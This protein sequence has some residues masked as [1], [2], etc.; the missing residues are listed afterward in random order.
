MNQTINQK[1]PLF[2][3]RKESLDKSILPIEEFKYNPMAG[4]WE[5]SV[6]EAIINIAFQNNVAVF[7]NTN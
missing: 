3:F 2:L 5:N 6:N 4:Y 7:G 1:N